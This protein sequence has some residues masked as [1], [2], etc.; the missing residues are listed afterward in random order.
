MRT[1]IIISCGDRKI[2]KK[3]LKAGPTKAKDAYIGPLFK[4]SRKY[5]ET[6]PDRYRWIIISAKYGFIDPDFIIPRKYDIK[7]GSPKSVTI[8]KLQRQIS[9]RCLRRYNKIILLAWSEYMGKIREA[10]E[11]NKKITIPA[12]KLRYGEKMRWLNRKIKQG[13]PL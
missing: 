11:N 9:K 5:A 13:K 6:F 3:N 12:L 1:L 4:V 7:M 2:W 8:Q 10:F